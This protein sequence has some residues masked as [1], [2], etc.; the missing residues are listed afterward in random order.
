MLLKDMGFPCAMLP[1]PTCC[2]PGAQKH[3]Q[4]KLTSQAGEGMVH[5]SE[6]SPRTLGIAPTGAGTLRAASFPWCAS[7]GVADASPQRWVVSLPCEQKCQV[8]PGGPSEVITALGATGKS[9]SSQGF[10]PGAQNP[11]S[12]IRYTTV[13]SHRQAECGTDKPAHPRVL[14][15]EKRTNDLPCKF[16]SSSHSSTDGLALLLHFPQ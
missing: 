10:L 4:V 14:G 9:R 2:I 5:A 12:K 16:L 1:L 11:G 15:V 8:T 13:E 6:S 7:S 3:P